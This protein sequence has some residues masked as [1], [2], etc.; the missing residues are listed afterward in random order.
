MK[1]G[2]EGMFATESR[3]D[4]ITVERKPAKTKAFPSSFSFLSNLE[5]VHT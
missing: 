1:M 5:L 2:E 3:C 4:V